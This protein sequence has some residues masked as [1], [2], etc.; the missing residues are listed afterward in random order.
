[1]RRHVGLVRKDVSEESVASNFRVE[2][3]ELGTLAET[4]KLLPLTLFL[5]R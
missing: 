4:S 3:S 5:A 1:M 2:K